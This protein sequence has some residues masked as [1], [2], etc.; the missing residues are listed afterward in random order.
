MVG[1]AIP[2]QCV[3]S[4]EKASDPLMHTLS[5][6]PYLFNRTFP[7]YRLTITGGLSSQ[8]HW[9]AFKFHSWLDFRSG[10]QLTG[11]QN[12]KGKGQLDEL[13]CVGTAVSN[14]VRLF[15]FQIST[16]AYLLS[17]LHIWRGRPWF[18]LHSCRTECVRFLYIFFFLISSNCT[19]YSANWI[20]TAPRSAVKQRW[21]GIQYLC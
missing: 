2:I 14:C 1:R 13:L 11:S 7:A 16:L 4:C 6:S 3:P 8:A 20:V 9:R 5:F 21:S 15:R 18:E 10:Y 19:C 12:P 17:G